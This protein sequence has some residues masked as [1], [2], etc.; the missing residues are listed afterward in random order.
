MPAVNLLRLFHFVSVALLALVPALFSFS[1]PTLAAQNAPALEELAERAARVKGIESRF[2]Q[3]RTISFMNEKLVS[4]G[5][6][7]FRRP[8]ELLWSY[9]SPVVFSLEYSKGEARFRSDFDGVKGPDGPGRAEA[10]LAAEAAKQ[11]MVWMT[12]DL[13]KI[14]EMYEVEI[15]GTEPMV[16]AVSP[17][18]KS[19]AFGI[20][21]M[22]VTFAPNGADVARIL[23]QERDGDSILLEFYETR[24]LE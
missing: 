22:R 23:M 15:A 4:Q 16:L 1:P 12:L 3:T 13:P 9:H 20:D 18:K 6:F 19:P 21:S 14:R 5:S 7:S 2:T 24:H 10:V 8:N 17:K 11:I